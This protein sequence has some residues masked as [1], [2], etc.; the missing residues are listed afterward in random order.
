MAPPARIDIAL[1]L[2]NLKTDFRAIYID[3]SLQGLGDFSATY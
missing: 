2:S 3:F 1:T